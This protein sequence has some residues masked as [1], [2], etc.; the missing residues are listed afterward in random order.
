MAKIY[1]F[2]GIIYNKKKIKKMDKVVSPPY[3]VI[4]PKMQDYYYQQSDFNTI[5]LILGKEFA[6]DTQYNNKYI[7]AAASFEGWLRHE[8]M[9]QDSKPAIYVYEQQFYLRGKK[10]IRLG[11]IALLRI[12]DSG[13]GR[14]YPHEATLQAPKLDRIELLRATHANFDCVFTLFSDEKNKI[15]KSF[16]EVMR[17]KPLIEVKDIDRVRHRF[18]RVETRSIINKVIKEMKDKSIFIADG[19]HR[20][21]AAIR[22]KNE[23][24]ERN[25]RFSEDEGYNHVMVY[26]TPVEGKGLL[27]LPINRLVKP[28]PYL[29]INHFEEELKNYFELK[30][31]PFSKRTEPKIRKKALRELEKGRAQHTFVMLIKDVPRYYIL[32]LKS[33]GMVDVLLEE[34][35][36]AALKHLDVTVLHAIVMNKILGV[37]TEDQINYAKDIEETVQGVLSGQYQ[38]AFLLNPTKVS[39]ILE[40]AGKLEKMPQKSTFFYPKLLSGLVLR[41]IVHGEKID[42]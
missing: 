37:S 1:P 2:K 20:Y 7:R 11:F 32:T 30:S 33:E 22:F 15:V 39:D 40:I 41:K 3:D 16:R 26:F 29:E 6:G 5:K 13:R 35:K 9:V 8:I 36:P 23:M 25:T 18:F 28:I 10:F 24:K 12:E 42:Y 34:E 17:R 4:S 19:H 27:V 38:L 14:L 31:L 21:E